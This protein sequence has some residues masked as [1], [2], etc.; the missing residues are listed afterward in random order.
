M[1]KP[2]IAASLAL[3]LSAAYATSLTLQQIR[4]SPTEIEA[5][6]A[7]DSGAGTSGVAGIRN[8]V[9]AG[10]PSKDAAW[11]ALFGSISLRA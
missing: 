5:I 10:D 2:I 4:L 8:T 11:T 7:H 1:R 6:Q 9:I 3:V